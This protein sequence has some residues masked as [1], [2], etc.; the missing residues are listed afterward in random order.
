VDWISLLDGASKLELFDL[1]IAIETYLIEKQKEWIQQNIITVHK[2]ALS[3]APL[4]RL[5]GYC[6]RLMVSHPDMVFKSNDFA[7]LPK[8]S[9]I[10]LLKHDDLSMHGR[11]RYLDVS[12][13]MGH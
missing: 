2:Y 4:N 12:Y 3:T 7:T 9:L 6:N 10:N 1:L 8:E 11:R 13:A 5:L